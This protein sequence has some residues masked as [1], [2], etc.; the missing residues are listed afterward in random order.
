[1]DNHDYFK[2]IAIILISTLVLAFTA[3][4]KDNS[5]LLTAII[6]FAVILSVNILVKKVAGYLLEIDVKT[7]FWTWSQFGF[8]ADHKFKKPIPMVWLPL[9]LALL[10]KGVFLWLAVLE[11]D[12][13][14]R[15]ER[16]TKRHGLYRFT[17]VTEWHIAWI[18]LWGIVAN[19]VLAVIG[20]L[21]GFELFSKLSIYYAIWSLVPVSNLDGAKIL[22]SSR[23]L[24]ITT[25]SIAAVF[26]FWAQII[27]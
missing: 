6:S 17:Q 4:Y 23:A 2:G 9:L 27:V 26:F 25:A 19:G 10:T 5:I 24:W 18:A 13:K 22:F 8:R 12:V 11:F 15:V 3:S 16:A 20:Y 21:A 1:M 14:P 7:K